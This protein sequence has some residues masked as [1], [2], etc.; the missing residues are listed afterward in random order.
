MLPLYDNITHKRLPIITCLLIFVNAAVFAYEIRLGLAG[1]RVLDNFVNLY[2]LVPA[3]VG[4]SFPLAERLLPFYTN[5][6]LHGGLLHLLG[7]MWFLWIF[8]DNVEDAFGHFNFFIFYIMCGLA[9]GVTHFFMN[10]AA[11]VPAVGA[12]GA[13]AG[14][15]GA[16]FWLY[17]KARVATLVPIVFFYWRVIQIPAFIFLGLWFIYQVAMSLAGTSALGAGI[18]F[19]AHVAGLILLRLFKK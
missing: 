5:M 4:M 13:I 3:K 15:L 19:W 2:G 17:P 14:V 12:S 7:N 16:Y 18:A 10:P 1:P 9:A 8:G 6:F 11:H